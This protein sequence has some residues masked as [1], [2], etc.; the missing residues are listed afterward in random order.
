MASITSIGPYD[1][2]FRREV[3]AYMSGQRN[4]DMPTATEFDCIR[5]FLRNLRNTPQNVTGYRAADG[6]TEV[7]SLSPCGHVIEFWNNGA[8]VGVIRRGTSP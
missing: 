1:P 8:L 6:S 2:Q 3:G 5:Q 7:I 4:P